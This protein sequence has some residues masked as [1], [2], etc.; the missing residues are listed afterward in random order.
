MPR[1]QVGSLRT[2]KDYSSPREGYLA[3][4]QQLTTY[5]SHDVDVRVDHPMPVLFDVG[6]PDASSL[7]DKIGLAHNYNSQT[8]L[9]L[10]SRPV[11]SSFNI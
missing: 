3:L 2:P 11:E 7:I 10:S 8:Q 5:L 4:L 6:Q 1:T 9:P